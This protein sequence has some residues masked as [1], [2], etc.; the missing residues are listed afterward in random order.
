MFSLSKTDVAVI[1]LNVMYYEMKMLG[2]DWAMRKE[3]SSVELVTM[4]EET[5][6]RSLAFPVAG[7]YSKKE[8][9]IKLDIVPSNMLRLPLS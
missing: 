1:A 4:Y 9:L 3:S 8:S 5:G 6:W 7:G 2:C